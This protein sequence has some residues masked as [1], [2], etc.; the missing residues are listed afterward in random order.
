MGQVTAAMT[1]SESDE[2][3][4]RELTNAPRQRRRFYRWAITDQNGQYA[5][6]DGESLGDLSPNPVILPIDKPAAVLIIAGEPPYTHD[7]DEHSAASKPSHEHLVESL[8]GHDRPAV[9]EHG[10]SSELRG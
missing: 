9:E 2:L 6:T 4:E 7:D 10:I 5:H 8:T 3:T 1:M